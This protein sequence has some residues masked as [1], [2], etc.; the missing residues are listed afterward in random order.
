[1]AR[2][3]LLAGFTTIRDLGG[4]RTSA[5]ALRD[6]IA[7]GLVPGPRMVTGIGLGT[8]GSHCDPT[9]GIRPG[10]VGLD[11]AREY[12]Y[13]GADAAAAAVRK[14]VRDGADV[15]KVCAT[16]GVLSIT[17]EIGPAQMTPAE[18]EAVIST[19]RMLN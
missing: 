14:A 17:D 15:I 9:T 5:L 19:A 10:H 18:L 11:A 1:N 6:A 4:S 3:T 13:D 2:T 7:R 16:A 8:T 12:T